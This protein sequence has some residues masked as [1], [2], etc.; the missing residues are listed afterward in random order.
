MASKRWTTLPGGRVTR[1]RKSHSDRR[2]GCWY[3][4]ML[5]SP[6]KWL[7]KQLHKCERQKT[8]I[9]IFRGEAEPFNY[10]HPTDGGN[11]W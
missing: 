6:P 3:T 8:R 10:V 2:P 7:R 11:Y 9:A 1:W 4:P 5:K